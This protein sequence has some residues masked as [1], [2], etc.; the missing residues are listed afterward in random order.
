MEIRE[1]PGITQIDT[2]GN[3]DEDRKVVNNLLAVAL[4]PSLSIEVRSAAA[5]AALTLVQIW[6]HPTFITTA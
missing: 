2:V 4:D 5:Q 3:W 6:S 1:A